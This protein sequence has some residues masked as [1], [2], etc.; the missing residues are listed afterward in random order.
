[1]NGLEVIGLVVLIALAIIVISGVL[2]LALVYISDRKA[3]AEDLETFKLD[4][5]SIGRVRHKKDDVLISI[6]EW[7]SARAKNR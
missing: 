2:F 7:K 1:M 5:Y 4:D 3:E 6:Q